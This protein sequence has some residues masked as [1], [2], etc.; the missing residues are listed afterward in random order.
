MYG[1]HIYSS[2]LKMCKKFKFNNSNNDRIV[3]KPLQRNSI[4][5]AA[6][7]LSINESEWKGRA[8]GIYFYPKV[9]ISDENDQKVE[10]AFQVQFNNSV[11]GTTPAADLF[12]NTYLV[13]N[14]STI[15]VA[16]HGKVSIEYFV[17]FYV[18][19]ELVAASTSVIIKLTK[20]P[21]LYKLIDEKCVCAAKDYRTKCSSDNKL[22]LVPSHWVSRPSGSIHACIEGYC[23]HCNMN[24]KS[25]IKRMCQYDSDA[26]C[27][28]ARS[29]TSRL[30]SRC[31]DGLSSCLGGN[32]CIDCRSSKYAYIWIMV[33]VVVCITLMLMLIVF[34][35]CNVFAA[36]C[37]PVILFY[38]LVPALLAREDIGTFNAVIFTLFN[39]NGRYF[40]RFC[41]TEDLDDLSKIWSRFVT[42]V[43][44][45]VMYALLLLASQKKPYLKLAVLRAWPVV[46][47]LYY[48]DVIKFFFYSINGINI[49]GKMYIYR[50]AEEEYL[51]K[52]HI[53]LFFVSTFTLVIT[54]SCMYAMW[55]AVKV[56][57]PILMEYNDEDDN[58]NSII[59]RRRIKWFLFFYTFYVGVFVGVAELVAAQ[60]ITWLLLLSVMF[61][62]GFVLE[63][64]YS[65]SML[66]TYE[67]LVYMNMLLIG[68]LN[69]NQD[70][71]EMTEDDELTTYY[72]VEVLLTL[73]F[74]SFLLWIVY[75]ALTFAGVLKWRFQNKSMRK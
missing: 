12:K 11:N 74:C 36:Y 40:K 44:W 26:P 65:S 67:T 13:G 70:L 75:T 18:I 52:R 72:L 37:I 71:S 3:F 57:N 73:P 68:V 29:Q 42:A 41:F 27:N 28:A 61:T 10:S 4:S 1:S 9:H 16:L 35:N 8:P 53:P 54:I 64:P 46:F 66:N 56:S 30:C 5:T 45:F 47:L 19:S 38:Q 62:G 15:S 24:N 22:F 50:Y 55:R 39:S 6:Y 7:K 31:R 17:N 58:M 69:H 63:K 43:L 59:S 2:T 34:L 48:V 32:S 14:L 51:S 33:I 49:D 25:S 20:C 21:L 23:A 60:D